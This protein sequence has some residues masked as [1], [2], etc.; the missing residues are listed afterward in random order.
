STPRNP[1]ISWDELEVRVID[2][3]T[4]WPRRAQGPRR[5][6][7]SSFGLSGTNAHVILEEAPSVSV[8]APVGARVGTVTVSGRDEAGLKAQIAKWA[9]W[10][11]EHPGQRLED[12]AYTSWAHRT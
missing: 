6:G 1:H 8:P 9:G 2:T 11:R 5:A 3:L 4:P 10:L 7:V 12:V